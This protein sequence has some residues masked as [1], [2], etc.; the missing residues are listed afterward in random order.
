[1]TTFILILWISSGGRAVTTAEFN[2]KDT[3]ETA[4]KAFMETMKTK[5]VSWFLGYICTPK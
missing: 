2:S 5:Q 4:G 3:C 1:M